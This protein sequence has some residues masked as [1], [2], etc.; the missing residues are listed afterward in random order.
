MT[1]F[2]TIKISFDF[3]CIQ[4]YAWRLYGWARRL[5]QVTRGSS[6]LLSSLWEAPLLPSIRHTLCAH[7]KQVR[8]QGYLWICRTSMGSRIASHLYAF[9]LLFSSFLD[10]L[11]FLSS[12]SAAK[13]WRRNISCRSFEWLVICVVYMWMQAQ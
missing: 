12:Y 2:L 8:G 3:S 13:R 7:M 1:Y 11:F 10:V 5:V 4:G 6:I 9:C